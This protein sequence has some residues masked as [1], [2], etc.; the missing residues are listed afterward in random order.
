MNAATIARIAGWETIADQR[1][2]TGT[3]VIVE[4]KQVTIRTRDG[5]S[6]HVPYGPADTL[7]SLHNALNDAV[8][9]STQGPR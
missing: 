3:K 2:P 6:A 9:A 5:R 1:L 8:Q 7:S 4:D